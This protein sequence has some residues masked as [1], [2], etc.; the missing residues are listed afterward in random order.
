M[1]A[2]KRPR[3]DGHGLPARA[4]IRCGIYTR[5]STQEGLDQVFNTLYAP[6]ITSIDIGS[7]AHELLS[8]RITQSSERIL[9]CDC[10]N[11]KSQSKRSLNIMLDKQA[12]CCLGGGTG[13]D[14]LQLVEFVHAGGITRGQSGRMPESHC[15][16]RDFLAD[17]LDAFSCSRRA[18]S[19][20][21]RGGGARA[22]EEP[23]RIR[24]DDSTCRLLP[25]H[26]RV[27]A[28][29]LHVV[30]GGLSNLHLPNRR[31]QAACRR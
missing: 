29:L 10:P 11:H 15:D 18:V 14:V 13:G 22:A 4:G 20:G 5:K 24:G 1:R 30:A 17:R 12:W 2:E 25:P 21:H 19:R 3:E 23:S 9:H 16:S 7:I 27:Q 31:W 6:K 8:G 28:G 26:E